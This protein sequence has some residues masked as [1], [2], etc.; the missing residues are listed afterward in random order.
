[1]IRDL[2]V[3]VHDGFVQ[4]LLMNTLEPVCNTAEKYRRVLVFSR[5]PNSITIFGI[6]ALKRFELDHA[7]DQTEVTSDC[8]LEHGSEVYRVL[9]QHLLDALTIDQEQG[10]L[11]LSL[12]SK[13]SRA[14]F[15]QLDVAEERGFRVGLETSLPDL[16]T[17]SSGEN[18]VD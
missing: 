9:M 12:D 15:E 7:V 17:D 5:I 4:V 8:P 1:M 3:F 18:Q 10:T 16:T 2:L 6:N 11:F 13:Q 14:L